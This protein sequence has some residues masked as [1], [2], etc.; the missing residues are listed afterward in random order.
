MTVVGNVRKVRLGVLHQAKARLRISDDDYRARLWREFGVKS[1]A[2]LSDA[3]LD[4]AIA[5]FHVKQT[6]ALQP[7][8]K[9][10]KALW[11]ALANLGA[12]EPSDTALDAFIER[13]T[14]KQSIRFLTAAES[15][16]VTEA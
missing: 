5:L 15:N 11:I 7:H 9:L 12:V 4:R 16:S 6:S 10:A 8:A 1:A 2:H 3:Q 14:G 13:Q